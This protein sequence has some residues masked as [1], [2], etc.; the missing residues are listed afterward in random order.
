MAE[1]EKIVAVMVIKDIPPG[2]PHSRCLQVLQ[3]T[4]EGQTF[5]STSGDLT[6]TVAVEGFGGLPQ[7]RDC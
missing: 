1:Q 6:F 2:M 4:I 5:Q 7:G 3:E